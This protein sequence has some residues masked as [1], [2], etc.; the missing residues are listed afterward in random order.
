MAEVENKTDKHTHTKRLNV[1]VKFKTI[2]HHWVNWK[3]IAAFPKQS[4][5]VVMSIKEK[6]K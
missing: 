6:P 4:Y 5:S 3:K 2:I 1:V